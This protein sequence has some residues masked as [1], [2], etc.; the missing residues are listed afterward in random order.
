[1]NA[2]PQA[3]RK[4]PVLVDLSLYGLDQ[5]SRTALRTSIVDNARGAFTRFGAGVEGVSVS[6]SRTAQLGEGELWA[7]LVDVTLAGSAARTVRSYAYA[8]RPHTALESALL[9]AW[10]DV[11]ALLRA[12]PT[13]E[14]ACNV[15]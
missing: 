10:S 13:P 6:V 9:D 11:D 4:L 5:G 15:A 8:R 2:P 14:P 3:L 7:V 1:M 12:Q